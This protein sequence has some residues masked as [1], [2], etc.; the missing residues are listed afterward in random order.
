M[1]VRSRT[2]IRQLVILNG[3][4]TAMIITPV[5]FTLVDNAYRTRGCFAFG[6]EW[7]A[8]A[9]LIAIVNFVTWKCIE[10]TTM[11]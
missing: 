2:W 1:S 9:I 3:C 10:L 8:L 11:K 5:G 7:I 4:L 6:I